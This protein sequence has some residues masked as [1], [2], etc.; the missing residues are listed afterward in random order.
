MNIKEIFILFLINLLTLSS[1]YNNEIYQNNKID[2]TSSPIISQSSVI[3]LPTTI[4]PIPTASLDLYKEKIAF[5]SNR[6]G[7][8][9]IYTMNSDGTNQT[10]LTKN[11]P[12]NIYPVWSPDGKKIAFI[13]TLTG[14]R[15][16]ERDQA[17]YVMDADGSNQIKLTPSNFVIG[18]LVWS[19]D[20][21]K[22]A[23]MADTLYLTSFNL[24][25][26]VVDVDKPNLIELANAHDLEKFP[27]TWVLSTASELSKPTWSP[28]SKK[29][30]FIY[31][32]I[33][34]NKE[35]YIMN[36]DKTNQTKLTYE[37]GGHLDSNV[38]W[39]PDGKKIAFSVN[40]KIYIMN[41]D[42]TNQTK[43]IQNNISGYC[44]VWS[45]DG[46]KIAFRMAASGLE[47]DLYVINV[48]GTNQ[49]KLSSFVTAWIR[50]SPD[51][52]KIIFVAH[53]ID[54]SNNI[55]EKNYNI[56]NNTIDK[57]IHEYVR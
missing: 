46:N 18:G 6:D 30:A 55:T 37:G 45:P 22:I 29:I 8:Y 1:C 50:W 27:A 10:R 40:S 41:S 24:Y 14:L 36:M 28:D 15:S 20:S 54:D 17:I 13:N 12:T 42:G 56:Y 25:I 34:G 32:L 11:N 51:S 21:K 16:Q 39:S 9:E 49:I 44:P 5:M 2:I 57:I 38:L 23:F 4:T 47:E 31:K 43:L 35:I 48:D 52:K 19:P 33:K 3:P 7:N 26:Y 53:K